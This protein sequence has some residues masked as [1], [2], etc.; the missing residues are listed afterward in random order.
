MR[1]TLF[2]FFVLTIYSGIAYSQKIKGTVTD[3]NGRILPYASVFIKENNKGT[4]ANSEGKY[5]LK[6]EAGNYTLVCQYVGYK[7]EERKITVSDND[8][9]LNFILT[10]QELTLGEVIVKNGEDP[11][12][13]IIRNTIK[14]R[15]FHE[16]Q[17]DKFECEV[18]TK[19]QLRLRDYP[20]KIFG[21]K[22]DFEDGDTSKKKIIFLSETISKYSVD[23]P[24][25]VKVEVMSSKVSGQTNGFGLAAPG[26][27]SF[28]GNNVFVGESLNPRGFISPIADNAL[29]FY[30]YKLEGS[31]F[32]DG[33]EISHIKVTPKRTYEPLFS[34]YIDI[35]AD[36]WRIHSVQLLLT[37]A[38]QM[39]RLD[40]LRIDQTYRPGNNDTWYVSSQVI[41]PAAKAMGFDLYG[42]F[43]N[44]YSDFKASPEFNRKSF[45]RTI[46]RYTD[47][48]TKKTE[49]YWDRTRPVPLM[50]DEIRDYIRKD[51][52]ALLRKDLRYTDS[53]DRIRN[54]I[55]PTNILLLGQS[56]QSEKNRTVIR[57]P[58][59]LELINFNPA[60]GWVAFPAFT[61]SKRPDTNLVSRRNITISPA[62]RYGFANKHFNAHLTASYTWGKKY[63][64]TMTVSGGKR[65]FQFNNNSPI[66][67]RGNTLSCLLSEENRI[68]SYEAIYFRG[69]FRKGVGGGISF[70]T[71]F[72]Y[73]DRMP[74]D[75][76]TNY[77]WRDKADR[78]YTPNYPS[79]IM[80]ANIQ[81]HQVFMIMAG[82]TWQPGARYIE[83]P[84]RKISVGSKHPVFSVE[85]LQAFKNVLGSDERF[86]KWKLGMRDDINF[87]LKGKFR[88]RLGIGGFIDTGSNVQVPDY[89]HFN[90]NISTLA[91]EYLNSFQLLPIY[92]FSN[93]SRFYALAHLEH[94]FNGFLTNKIPGIK[95]LNLYLVT[96]ANGF[97]INSNKYY[98]ELSVGFDNI[99]KQLRFDFVQSFV[100]GKASQHGFR[101]GFGRLGGNRGD[102]WP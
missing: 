28:Y 82:L 70:V 54:K 69:S 79:E 71:G 37:K 3:N 27:M 19:G 102:D 47:S 34:G 1:Q 43:V 94:N 15:P 57:F 84:G 91:T 36:D 78:A 2:F 6:L 51:S 9:E 74:L 50:D 8:I 68:K 30:R 88:Y 72:Q 25:K 22:I 13:P 83:L 12:N 59:L 20:D 38:S 58:S 46:V 100:N 31:Y 93:I 61:W 60:E 101:L 23:R 96:A 18:Y 62:L 67:L 7:K 80:S 56:F 86:S 77:T 89:N 16:N 92:Q 40:T 63:I 87:K 76:R 66:G 17:L 4:N 39:E 44:I 24:N 29:N 81:R 11:A 55:T 98:Y 99:F 65:V 53:L 21:Q 26:Y 14:K 49:E 35:V 33:R 90:G 95:K 75:N 45:S 64:S 32:E 42:S 85:Y 73:Q 97:Y 5:S 10:L 48:S 52:L 41:Y